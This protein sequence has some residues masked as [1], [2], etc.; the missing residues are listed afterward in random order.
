MNITKISSLFTFTISILFSCISCTSQENG[1]IDLVK[2]KRV[3]LAFMGVQPAYDLALIGDYAFVSS[4]KQIVSISISDP[5]NASKVGFVE[6][7]GPC[8]GLYSHENLLF[9]V[10]EPGLIIID[11]TDPEN[12]QVIGRYEEQGY[13]HQV[14][15]TA[16]HAYVATDRGVQVIDVSDCNCPKY[17]RTLNSD[18]VYGIEIHG[19]MLLAGYKNIGMIT[20]DISNPAAIRELSKHPAQ[21][22]VIMSDK[23][24]DRLF[25][26]SGQGIVI[27]NIF[28]KTISE[29]L[30]TYSPDQELRSIFANDQY[31]FV[32]EIVGVEIVD[33]STPELPVKVAEYDKLRNLHELIARNHY[34]YITDG[35][36]FYTLCY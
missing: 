12:P 17:L 26:C 27:N 5:E 1:L 7:P 29:K 15:V 3:N 2:V 31:L 22:G 25:S 30:G 11:P 32:G 28:G 10:G 6:I 8:F 20:Y 16:Q 13:S 24:N 9:A 34:I 18:H 21:G 23:D 4:N 14:R 19:D 33:I 35:S 36:G